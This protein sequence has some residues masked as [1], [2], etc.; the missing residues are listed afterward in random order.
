[1]NTRKLDIKRLLREQVE[2]DVKDE[3]PDVTT[4]DIRH[5]ERVVG[6]IAVAPVKDMDYT[7][8]IVNITINPNDVYQAMNLINKTIVSL[9][10][11]FESIHRFILTTK[12]ESRAFWHKMG[13]NRLNDN[14][15]MLQRGH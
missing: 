8:E 14:Y 3:T 1:M 13:A 11:E 12:P 6:R 9:W 4:Y 7:M 10:G 2:L 15:L 5:N